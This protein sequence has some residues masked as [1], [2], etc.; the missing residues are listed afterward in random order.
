[1]G[2]KVME[3]KLNKDWSKAGSIKII[4]IPRGFFLVLSK[5]EEDYKRALFEGPCKVVNHYILVQR[6]RPS[7]MASAQLVRKVVVWICVPGL[8]IELYND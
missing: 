8:S 6:W 5:R 7:F 2:F 1:M 3:N 4:D